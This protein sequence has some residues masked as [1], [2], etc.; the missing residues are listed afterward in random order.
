MARLS[1]PTVLMGSEGSAAAS[2]LALWLSAAVFLK[3]PKCDE[4]VRF[5]ISP[6]YPLQDP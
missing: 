6:H 1:I 5:G 2:S 3:G 4:S